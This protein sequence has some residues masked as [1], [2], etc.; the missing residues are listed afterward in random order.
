MNIFVRELKANLKSL[1]VW[2]AIIAL[3]I[4]M[5]VSK[6]S[7][8]ASDPATLKILDDLPKAVLDVFQMNTFNMTTIVGLYGIMY[9]YFALMAGL[10]AVM[11]GSDIISKEERDKTVEFSLTLPVA[12]HQ[13]ITGKLLAA[14]VHCIAFELAIG[15]FSLIFT[16]TYSPDGAFYR[17]LALILVALFVTQM[18]F[19]AIGILLGAALK[20]YKQA[21]SIAVA[22]LM[23]TYIFSI[24]MD[25]EK[26]LNFLRYFTPFKYFNLLTLLNESKF[27]PFYLVLSLLIVAASLGAAYW[28]YARRDLYI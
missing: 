3:L 6:F 18:V 20:Q 21:S 19:L 13:V 9:V 14:V 15:V 4:V 12:R 22:V 8:F 25:L 5:A 1:L 17:F 28:A 23:I 2:S 16:A 27:E 11:L 10:F 24:L 7:A 26:N